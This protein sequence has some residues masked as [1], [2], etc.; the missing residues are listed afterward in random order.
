M[1]ASMRVLSGADWLGM[2]TMGTGNTEGER[3]THS[4]IHTIDQAYLP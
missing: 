1:S 4:L 2:T 3:I